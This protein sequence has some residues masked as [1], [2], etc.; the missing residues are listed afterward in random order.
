MGAA[1]QR[2]DLEL[3]PLSSADGTLLWEQRTNSGLAVRIDHDDNV[4][5]VGNPWNPSTLTVDFYA[6]KYAATNGALLWERRLANGGAIAVALDAKDNVVVTG[7]TNI[8]N[9]SNGTELY[10]TK[11]ASANGALIWQNGYNSNG[12]GNP[13][14]VGHA[15]AVDPIGNVVVTAFSVGSGTSADFYTAKYAATNG[16]LLW[17]KRYNGPGNSADYPCTN[18][19]ALGSNGMVVVAGAS[20][21]SGAAYFDYTTIVYREMLPAVSGEKVST[22]VRLHFPGVANHSYNVERASSL[23]GP[24]S[25]NAVLTALTNGVIEYIDTNAPPGSA[26]YRTSTAP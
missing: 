11:Y 12:S 18:C 23:T 14:N 21:G 8:V 10:T 6:A 2:R 13:H 25:T 1:Y 5:T 24:W 15:V 20:T 17:E 16:A 9:P 4:V 3:S 7:S 26:F 19:I 22:G